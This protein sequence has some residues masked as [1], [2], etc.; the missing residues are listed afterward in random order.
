MSS[1]GLSWALLAL[2]AVVMGTRAGDRLR[3]GATGLVLAALGAASLEAGAGSDVPAQLA[4][5]AA[6][7]TADR[8][9]LEIS[10]GI[11]LLG[12]A[13]TAVGSRSWAVLAALVLLAGYGRPLLQVTGLV[14]PIGYA[15]AGGGAVALLWA[16]AGALRPGRGRAEGRET[17]SAGWLPLTTLG[18]G[19]A[20]AAAPNALLTLGCAGGGIALAA[21]LPVRAG[22]A[23]R[24]VLPLALLLT[25]F[26]LAL[27]VTII[28][29]LPASFATL[30]DGPFSDAASVLLVLLLGLVAHVTSGG[31]PAGAAVPGVLLLPVA[32]ALLGRFGAG[33][34]PFGIAFWQPA[35][36]PLTLASLAY[37]L[38]RGRADLVC[39]A[40][41]MAGLWSGTGPGRVGAALLVVGSLVVGA[42]RQPV[43]MPGIPG[44]AWRMGWLVP[45]IGGVLVL[46][47]LLTTQ[48]VYSVLLVLLLALGLAPPFQWPRRGVAPSDS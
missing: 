3:W 12:V 8:G 6:T 22:K 32:W 11:L 28:G 47:A 41:A 42:D 25:G 7:A 23:G 14:R 46:G 20:A 17:P 34:V 30:P 35:A 19:I 48:V 33:A 39:S 18:L 27:S 31:W 24:L 44:P 45:G 43:R 1:I 38:M 13:V 29:P 40:L 9:F 16:A 21:L 15:A 2:A 37:G 36:V 26:A 10:V 4:R 5:L